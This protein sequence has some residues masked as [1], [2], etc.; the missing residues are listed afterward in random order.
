MQNVNLLLR[1]VSEVE[2]PD[3]VELWPQIFQ[4]VR[5]SNLRRRQRRA[6]FAV[7]FLLLIASLPL[8]MAGASDLLH[9]SGLFLVPSLD[10]GPTFTAPGAT[11]VG[12]AL[13]SLSLEAAQEKARFRIPTPAT[14]PDGLAFSHAFVAPD[15]QAVV[16]VYRQGGAA[17][18]TLWIQIEL[19][20]TGGGYVL[21]EAAAQE[22]TVGGRPAVYVRGENGDGGRWN[23][24]ADAIK[25]GWRNAEL[26]YVLSASGLGL[27]P[28][29]VVQIAE[30]LR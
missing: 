5:Q 16:L 19:G 26:T 23:A 24:Q 18:R 3:G 30:S 1:Y 10:S 13:S 11:A 21:P 28:S 14:L 17:N 20:A 25:L 8:A 27:G 7:G 4:G 15:G 12:G 2:V 22:I 29:D 9:R 6:A